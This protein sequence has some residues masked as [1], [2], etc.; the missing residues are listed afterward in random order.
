MSWS[1]D[2]TSNNRN[3]LVSTKKQAPQSHPSWN[4]S[5]WERLVCNNHNDHRLGYV[6]RSSE[7]A[8]GHPFAPQLRRIFVGACR[9][10]SP[11]NVRT[12][13]TLRLRDAIKNP[14]KGWQF[15]SEMGGVY[16]FIRLSSWTHWAL[17]GH[18]GWSLCQASS[19]SDISFASLPGGVLRL[20]PDMS[21][22]FLQDH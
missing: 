4:E 18:D 16:W 8:S 9:T 1:C 15:Y 13:E 22:G 3:R 21:E 17:A 14:V 10:S 12:N 19:L 5:A 2:G 6:A 7:A 20:K 11:K